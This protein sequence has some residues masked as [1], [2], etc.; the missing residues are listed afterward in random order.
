MRNCSLLG[1]LALIVALAGI[2]G[3]AAAQEA[4]PGFVT[5]AA[6]PSMDASSVAMRMPATPAPTVSVQ[7][8]MRRST[9][10][11]LIGGGIFLAGALIGGD[12]GALIMIG[13]A[14]TGLYGLYIYLDQEAAAPASTSLTATP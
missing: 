2:H 3:S 5:A 7:Q 10:L 9:T 11:M 13:G 1:A 4:V 6:V 12:A 8:G 14:A